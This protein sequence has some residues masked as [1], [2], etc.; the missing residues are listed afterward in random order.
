MQNDL[1]HRPKPDE[2]NKSIFE[3]RM[4]NPGRHKFE[5]NGDGHNY[6]Q[7]S[8]WWCGKDEAAHKKGGP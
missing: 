7:N 8:C 6:A 5:A 2:P 3:E 4:D 1:F